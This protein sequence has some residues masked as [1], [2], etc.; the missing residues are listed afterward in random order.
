MCLL[1]CPL[2]MSLLQFHLRLAFSV[3]APSSDCQGRFTDPHLPTYEYLLVGG[4]P[5][6]PKGNQAAPK[7]AGLALA[8]GKILYNSKE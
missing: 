5:N 1:E 4:C 6:I 2:A 7:E 3:C 8:S